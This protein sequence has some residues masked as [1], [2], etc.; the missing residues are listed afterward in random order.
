[1]NEIG[2]KQFE[3][4][5]TYQDKW[6]IFNNV[7]NWGDCSGRSRF[8]YGIMG[9]HQNARWHGYHTTDYH[10]WQYMA[11]QMEWNEWATHF[12]L[13]H[14]PYKTSSNND[15]GFGVDFLMGALLF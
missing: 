9:F 5:K 12:K 15:L 6:Q 3:S 4:F 11:T 13:K 1:L 2:K 10:S 8:L 7:Y 14:G